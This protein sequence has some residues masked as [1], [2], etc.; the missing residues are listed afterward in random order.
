MTIPSIS[1][2]IFN[3]VITGYSPSTWS[4]ATYNIEEG[5]PSGYILNQVWVDSEYAYS[6]GDDGLNIYELVDESEYFSIEY[7]GGFS[8]I[9]GNDDY[10]FLGTSDSGVKYIDKTSISGGLNNLSNLTYY[11][12]LTSETISYIHG[13]NDKILCVTNSGID[14][15]KL[16]P[17]SYRSFTTINGANKCFMNSDEEIYYTV[18]NGVDWTIYKVNSITHD[19]NIPDKIYDIFEGVTINDIFVDSGMIYTATSNGVYVIDES[20]DTYSVLT[21]VSGIKGSSN[22]F[23]SVWILNNKMYVSSDDT[24]TVVDLLTNIVHDWYSQTHIGR[25][26]ESLDNDSIVDIIVG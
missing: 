1:G 12:T 21:T 9:W 22:N 18:L 24:L 6:V 23:S 2:G 8:T 4:G 7:S 5:T 19:W 26:N 11:S 17:Q 10:I 14:V 16:D 15:V 25:A 20:N 13:Y 3:F